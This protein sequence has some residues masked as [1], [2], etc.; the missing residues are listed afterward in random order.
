MMT[1][2]FCMSRTTIVTFEWVESWFRYIW[3]RLPNYLKKREKT[4]TFSI[5]V[6][7]TGS[8]SKLK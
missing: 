5:H 2:L 4:I 1:K 6:R 8:W 3:L 7:L